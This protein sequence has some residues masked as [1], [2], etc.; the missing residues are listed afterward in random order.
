MKTAD[1]TAPSARFRLIDHNGHPVDQDTFHGSYALLFFGSIHQQL[2]QPGDLDKLWWVLAR[3]E[4]GPDRLR[5]LYVTLNPEQDT[6]AV[7]RTFLRNYPLFMGLTGTPEQV[8]RVKRNFHLFAWHR[9]D[10]T[11]EYPGPHSSLTYLLDTRGRMLDHWHDSIAAEELLL[12]LSSVLS[13]DAAVT[14][15]QDRLQASSPAPS[16]PS[17][18][19][20]PAPRASDSPEIA[21]FR[22]ASAHRSIASGESAG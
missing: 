6:P 21:L 16:Q 2:A 8:G 22:P 14:R 17:S 1:L 15:V 12:R 5:A 7:L 19:N 10:S 4:D 11:R 3:M 13:A 9:A 18:A 20:Q